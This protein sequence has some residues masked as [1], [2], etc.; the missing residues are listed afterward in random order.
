MH[1][2]MRINVTKK[3][4]PDGIAMFRSVSVREKILC[5]LLGGKARMT[6]IV[7]GDTVSEVAITEIKEGAD[8]NE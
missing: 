3:P 7:P 2:T 5:R 1:H 8:E 6:V 4:K